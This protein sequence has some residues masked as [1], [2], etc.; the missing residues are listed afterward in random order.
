MGERELVSLLVS[1]GVSLFGVLLQAIIS[2]YTKSVVAD[3]RNE[4][5]TVLD[6]TREEFEGKFVTR[7]L[8]EAHRKA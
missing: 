1:A 4:M 2:L 6:D 5:H 3:L 7:E 8:W